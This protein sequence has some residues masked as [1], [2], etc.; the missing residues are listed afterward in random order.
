MNLCFENKTIDFS[1]DAPASKS[2]AH[3]ELIVRFL[4]GD[5][6]NLS[7]EQSDNEDILATKA[8][9]SALDKAIRNASEEKNTEDV[10]LFCN[11]SGS[12]LR[13]M[14]P[15]AAAF[16]LG[17]HRLTGVR[18]IIFET[19]GRLFDRPVKELQDALFPHG[20]TIRKEESTRRILVSGSMTPGEYTIDGSVSSQ[21]ISGLL[22]ALPLLDAPSTICIF[23][24]LKSV[25][26]L[27]LTEDAL[28]KYDNPVCLKENVY[29]VDAP[30]YRKFPSKELNVEGDWSNG[31]FLLCLKL[32]SDITV[33]NLNYSSRQ[34]DI[35]I[36]DFLKQTDG[37]D[38]HNGPAVKETTVNCNDTPDIAPYMACVAPFF[39]E[40]TVLSGIGRLRIK[41]S[42]RVKAVREQLDAFHVKTEESEDT[43]IIY[44][45]SYYPRN[46]ESAESFG[47]SPVVLSSYHD[48][49]MAMCAVLLGVIHRKNVEIDDINCLNKSFP[50]FISVIET[51]FS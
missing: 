26:Y 8:C 48:H 20:I 24:E 28:S 6:A 19:K 9:L 2:I 37:I 10:I 16:L 3:R 4:C 44:G 50:E 14:I 27:K 11:E 29:S 15:V 40:K 49:R 31:A 23:N 18:E 30:G 46:G 42:D 47:S 33:N 5:R 13:F 41:E 7:P 1:I 43:L 35:A 36:L 38:Y 25:H 22:M 34:G 12:T 17:S 32:F 39:F 21:Y 45:S 51:C